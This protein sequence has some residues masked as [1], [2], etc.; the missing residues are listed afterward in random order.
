MHVQLSLRAE[1]KCGNI[2]VSDVKRAVTYIHVRHAICVGLTQQN[3]QLSKPH[4]VVILKKA[5]K[6]I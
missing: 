5:K 2:L 6:C 4:S 3:L 1:C